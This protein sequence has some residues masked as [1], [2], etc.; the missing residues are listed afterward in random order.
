[1]TAQKI[2]SNVAFYALVVV[3]VVFSVWRPVRLFFGDRAVLKGLI[4]FQFLLQH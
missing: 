2:L 1:M 4:Q 3:I